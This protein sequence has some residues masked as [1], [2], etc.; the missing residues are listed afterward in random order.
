MPDV[1]LPRLYLLRIGYAFIAFGMGAQIY[2]RLLGATANAPFNEGVVDAMLSA[3]ALLSLI[4]IAAPL[5]MLPILIYEITWKAT[6]F[7][8]VA[9]PRWR[10]GSL[11]DAIT[12]N[13]FAIG[14]VIPYIFIAPWGYFFKSISCNLDRWR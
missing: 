5:R 10:D 2:P 1:S 3:L 12:E 9:F 7:A 13:L 8:A 14:L 11:E 6:W 4:G